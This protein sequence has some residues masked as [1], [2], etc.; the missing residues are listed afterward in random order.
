MSPELFILSRGK[1]DGAS[2]IY[3]SSGETIMLE[4]EGIQGPWELWFEKV[5]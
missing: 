1:A 2:T 5:N 4:L 3:V